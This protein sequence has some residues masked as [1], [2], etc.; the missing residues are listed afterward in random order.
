MW[1][2]SLP[3]ELP[4]LHEVRLRPLADPRRDDERQR[5]RHQRDQRQ[6]R[7]DPEHHHQHADDGQ[8]RVD[9]L[10]HRLLERL[11]DV[12]DVVR[13]PAQHLTA[14]LLV[15]VRQRQPRQLRLHVLAHPEDGPVDRPGS[16]AAS[17][18][19]I[20]SPAHDV[21]RQRQQ[22]DAAHRA[23]V[24]ALARG[25]VRARTACRR[26]RRSPSL[27]QAVEGLLLAWCRPAS[28]G[29]RCPRRSGRWPCRGSSARPRSAPTLSDH[30]APASRTA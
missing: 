5:H 8:Q 14:L 25:E 6:Q 13:R 27:A 20:S 1:A 19:A 29:R 18:P 26:A 28:A 16:T 10:A 12:V 17:P 11:P 22:Q 9:E 7:R 2:L 30:A 15:E 24:D 21:H 4:L 3:V 23:E